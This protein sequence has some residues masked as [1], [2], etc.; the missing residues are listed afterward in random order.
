M[1]ENDNDKNK[2]S[3]LQMKNKEK[4]NFQNEDILKYLVYDEMS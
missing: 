2:I 3:K 4:R 1:E